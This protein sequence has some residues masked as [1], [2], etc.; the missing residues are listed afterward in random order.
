MQGQDARSSY[1][2]DKVTTM[3]SNFLDAA[4]FMCKDFQM[5]VDLLCLSVIFESMPIT[6]IINL[7]KIVFHRP[8]VNS[9]FFINISIKC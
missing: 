7:F 8:V 3:V 5:I 9:L 4:R 6:I 1:S 2:Q